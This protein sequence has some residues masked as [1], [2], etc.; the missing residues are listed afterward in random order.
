MHVI[1]GATGHTGSVVAEKLLA[2]GEQVRVIGR[3]KSRL[4]RFTRKGAEAVL[5]DITDAGALARAFAGAKAAYAMIPPNIGSASVNVYQKRVNEA[6]ASAIEK[7]KIPHAVALSSVGA[8]KPDRTGPVLGLRELEEKLGAI[9]GLNVLFLRAGYFMENILPQAS[10]VKSYGKM[11]GP[12][13]ADLKLPMIATRDIGAAAAEAL[14][15]LDFHGKQ[16]RELL[17]PRDVSYAEVAKAAG[18]AIGKP[19]LEYAQAPAAQIKLGMVQM[20]MSSN[21]A[22]LLLEMSEALNAGYMKALEPRSAANTTPTT[23]ETFLK[24]E[25]VPAYQEKAARA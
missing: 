16:T 14:R 24:E 2:A 25:F 21:V 4:E 23:I 8:D 7:N 13:R 15:K 20:G 5:A 6:I 3:D 1:T 11:M 19:D 12:V 9:P 10:L 22:E 17:G 18:A